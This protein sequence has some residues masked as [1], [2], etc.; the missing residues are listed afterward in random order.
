MAKEQ[1]QP[2]KCQT[3]CKEYINGHCKLRI[4]DIPNDYSKV[5]LNSLC[6]YYVK[7]KTLFGD[8]K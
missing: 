7:V 8:E 6:G 3:D 1:K 2:E 5:N 4:K